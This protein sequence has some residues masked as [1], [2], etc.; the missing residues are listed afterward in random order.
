MTDL[1]F[2]IEKNDLILLCQEAILSRF[3]CDRK[4]VLIEIF[5]WKM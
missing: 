4:P 1:P 5:P 3:Q 2:H